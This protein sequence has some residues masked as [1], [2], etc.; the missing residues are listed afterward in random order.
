MK[1]CIGASANQP[2]IVRSAIS[3]AIFNRCA[4]DSSRK[5]AAPAGRQRPQHAGIAAPLEPLGQH[6]PHASMTH[7][8]TYAEA[9][10]SSSELMPLSQPC[11]HAV[12]ATHGRDKCRRTGHVS[13]TTCHATGP[14]YLYPGLDISYL[15][16]CPSVYPSGYLSVCLSVGGRGGFVRRGGRVQDA[17][18]WMLEHWCDR[19]G[20]LWPLQ[21]AAGAAVGLDSP[22]ALLGAMYT[23]AVR[24]GGP[25][26][27]THRARA[28]ALAWHALRAGPD[29]SESLSWDVVR[30]LPLL[31][32]RRKPV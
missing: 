14:R 10:R 7:V 21:Q 20:S 9:H 2:Q 25:R 32:Q 11:M 8:R 22:V 1:Y 12:P 26:G 3:S 4:C 15:P 30:P 24:R 13:V 23:T 6:Q 31:T 29:P 19:G 18:D 27:Y 5:S 17:W 28:Y 16:I